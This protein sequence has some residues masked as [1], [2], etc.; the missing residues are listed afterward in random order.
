M[1]WISKNLTLDLLAIGIDAMQKAYDRI[2][3]EPETAGEWPPADSPAAASASTKAKFEAAA[4]T[5][6]ESLEAAQKAEALAETAA[7]TAELHAKAQ[8]VLRS[9]SLDE[10]PEWITGVLFPKYGVSTLNAVPAD[11]LADLVADAE[12]HANGKAAA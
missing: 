11:K 6:N 7:N 10:G 12:E 9:I 5:A 3:T 8:T 4:R 2:K 1:T